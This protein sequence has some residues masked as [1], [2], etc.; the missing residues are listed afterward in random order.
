MRGMPDQ[1]DDNGFAQSW[2][3][4][5][6]VVWTTFLSPLP[7]DKRGDWQELADFYEN[8]QRSGYEV[9]MSD[10][11]QAHWRADPPLNG[12]VELPL[13]A[14]FCVEQDLRQLTS[15]SGDRVAG[16]SPVLSVAAE[17]TRVQL[18]FSCPPSPLC[19]RV[20][21]LKSR[22]ATLLAFRPEWGVGGPRT[23]SRGFWWARLPNEDLAHLASDFVSRQTSH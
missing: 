17:P 5:W 8:L 11:L 19:Q 10:A 7:H 16:N 18:V 9:E 15:A 12:T 21:R 4:W 3:H 14:C 6:H 22:S 1:F 23:W 13:G 2:F 20:G